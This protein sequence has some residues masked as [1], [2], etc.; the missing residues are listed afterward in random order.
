MDRRLPN[1]RHMDAESG[2]VYGSHNTVKSINPY[3]TY[4]I[5]H[6]PDSRVIKGNN[7]FDTGWNELSDGISLLQYHL[8]TGHLINI[9]KYRSYLAL[10]EVSESLEGARIFHSINVKGMGDSGV[11]NYKIILKEDNISKYKIGDILITKDS[12]VTKSPHWKLSV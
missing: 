1:F 3:K 9:P 10:I 2:R 8:S 6:Y 11:I 12:K 7:L 5:A 4:F